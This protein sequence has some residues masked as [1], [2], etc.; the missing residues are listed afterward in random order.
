MPLSWN[1]ESADQV[2]RT[3]LQSAGLSEPQAKLIRFYRNA[4]FHLPDNRLAL[5]IYGPEEARKQAQLMVSFSR[6]LEDRDFPSVRLSRLFDPQPMEILGTQISVWNWIDQDGQGSKQPRD[7]GA[8]LRALH[9]VTDRAGFPMERFDPISKIGNRLDRL[10]AELR[11]PTADL[12][13]LDAA[14]K[15]VA[16]L[17]AQVSNAETGSALLHGDALIGNTILSGGKLF[18]IDF[19]SVGYGAREW[20]LAPTLVTATRFRQRDDVWKQFL[21]GYGT[22]A[23]SLPVI[24]AAGVVKQFSMTIALCLSRGLS[25]AIDDEIALRIRCWADWDFRTPWRTPTLLPD[26]NGDNRR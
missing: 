8:L 3:F 24:E 22:E 21:A 23:V 15:R 14:W 25:S 4:V 26:T 13:V 6:L 9:S 5:R 7:F 11:L 10:K 2:A 18:L 20:D 12:Q 19:D 1:V 17:A 16:H